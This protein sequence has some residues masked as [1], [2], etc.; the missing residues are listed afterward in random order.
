M[1]YVRR[2]RSHGREL[3]RLL[4]ALMA[5]I[6]PRMV[7]CIANRTSIDGQRRGG[8][9]ALCNRWTMMQTVNPSW[10]VFRPIWLLQAKTFLNTLRYQRRTAALG[11]RWHLQEALR[12]YAKFTIIIEQRVNASGCKVTLLGVGHNVTQCSP[13]RFMPLTVINRFVYCRYESNQR[14]LRFPWTKEVLVPKEWHRS[15]GV[16]QLERQPGQPTDSLKENE[17]SQ[18]VVSL[19][20]FAN[21]QGPVVG[22]FQRNRL[23]PVSRLERHDVVATPFI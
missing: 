2:W 10:A 20:V 21:V 14:C 15:H 7:L 18:R 13:M 8:A 16:A 17:A 1:Q 4:D 23:S 19:A 9:D 6:T 22:A 12:V 11:V 5:N 3:L